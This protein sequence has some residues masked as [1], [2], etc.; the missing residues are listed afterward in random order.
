MA[1]QG[2]GA[3]EELDSRNASIKRAHD[4]DDTVPVESFP[5]KHAKRQK[6]SGNWN[7]GTK[8]A[9]RTSLS[10]TEQYANHDEDQHSVNAQ[11]EILE[12]QPSRDEHE[13]FY[14]Q[15]SPDP[16]LATRDGDD[17]EDNDD[18]VMLNVEV[19]EQESGEISENPLEA[20]GDLE[21]GVE[22]GLR[23]VSQGTDVDEY[24]HA[25]EE[26]DAMADYADA[27]RI[28]A[29]QQQ[30][31]AE[32]QVEAEDNRHPRVLADLDEEDLDAQLRYF[33]VAQDPQ[34][35]DFASIPVRCLV[36]TRAGHVGQEC[37]VLTCADCGS[38]N[39][40]FIPFCPR[41]EKCS[42]CKS[43]GHDEATCPNKLKLAVSEVICDLCHDSGHTE[44]ECELLWRTSGPT[45]PLNKSDKRW[46]YIYCYE[47]GGRS[48]LGNDCP[49]R[50]PGKPMGTATWSTTGKTFSGQRQYKNSKSGLAIKGRAQQQRKPETISLD[51]DS[52]NHTGFVR[53]KLPEPTNR[54]SIR[55]TAPKEVNMRYFPKNKPEE[56]YLLHRFDSG[57]SQRQ[58][59]IEPYREDASTFKRPTN[60][61]P[62]YSGNPG[63]RSRPNPN[64]QPPP[65]PPARPDSGYPLR[66]R[67][68]QG[69]TYRPMPSAGQNAW[70]QYR[71]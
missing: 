30:L 4:A 31:D 6:F 5:Q 63:T 58:P 29:P 64:Y 49:T 66:S 24:N 44:Y 71:R 69:Q 15:L 13:R 34:R 51:S 46:L 37:P 18:D 9:I 67:P 45:K 19:D 41:K 36:C 28:T 70:Q 1:E 32:S 59:Y 22:A 11:E 27:S 25:S 14:V 17:S 12:V 21:N 52:D 57:K 16:K 23:Q 68:P 42:K 62:W 47:C 33:Y 56:Q 2:G 65:P 7:A 55:I 10:I 40:H 3:T 8:S 20:E 61:P 38:Y 53:P 50:R 54:G 48:H 26:V 43:Q 35:L 39:A 60:N